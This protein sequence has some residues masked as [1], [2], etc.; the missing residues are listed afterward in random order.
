MCNCGCTME[1][2]TMA[3][4]VLRSP[5]PRSR[6]Y[7]CL[8]HK[9]SH[10]ARGEHSGMISRCI[11]FSLQWRQN[12]SVWALGSS[13]NTAKWRLFLKVD[14]FCHEHLMMRTLLMRC[15]QQTFKTS[16][17]TTRAKATRVCCMFSLDD[18][19]ALCVA[20][21]PACMHHTHKSPFV[22]SKYMLPN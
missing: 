5:S 19:A 16:A 12:C 17:R 22:Q 20:T 11:H 3:V 4:V 21:F 15:R 7:V 14:A 6:A 18:K 13:C 9:R 10:V 8:K 1:R 2:C